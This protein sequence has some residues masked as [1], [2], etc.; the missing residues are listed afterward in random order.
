MGNLQPTI[1]TI[2]RIE[3]HADELYPANLNQDAFTTAV[4]SARRLP[5]H[6]HY[7]IVK[8]RS[9]GLVRSDPIA[10]PDDLKL[11]YRHSSFDY[12]EETNHLRQTY[13]TYLQRLE[14]LGVTKGSLLEIGCGNG[15]FLEEALNQGY[16]CVYGVEPSQDA[17]KHASPLI[18][19]NIYG[20]IMERD[21]YEAESF[22]VICLFQVIDHLIDPLS[23][24]KDCFHLLKKNGFLLAI[25]HNIQ[26]S[27][28]II[29]GES[30]PI[31]DVE[32]TYLFAPKTMRLLC[33][34]SG[35]QVREQGKVINAYS[36]Y[37]LV[38]LL[39]I[40]DSFKTILLR[41]LKNNHLDA[42]SLRMP[43]GNM[44]LIGQKVG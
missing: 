18:R 32:H 13:G 36:L 20:G 7:R 41:G 43:L 26:A 6:L 19:Q 16:P 37:Y 2:C 33:E 30:S 11:L 12:Q 21:L 29:L 17:I 28:A 15:F 10:P 22:D 34:K 31:I 23:V 9:C 4:F 14:S 39:P 5:D 8:C 44:Y 35:F 38:R 24:L 3:S 27:S 25:N 1:C 42:K 40:K